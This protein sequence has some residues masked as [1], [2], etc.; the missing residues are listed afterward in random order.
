MRRASFV[1]SLLM[2]SACP[3]DPK[4]EPAPADTAPPAP[5]PHI[6]RSDKSKEDIRAFLGDQGIQVKAVAPLPP[7]TELS[8]AA[9]KRDQ[10]TLADDSKVEI[11]RFASNKAAMECQS[12]IQTKQGAAWDSVSDNYFVHGRW[13]IVT[14]TGYPAD[15]RGKLQHAFDQAL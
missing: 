3:K 15:A 13:L 7:M 12:V 9:D 2:L 10:L 14:P 1:C 8:C 11:D 4:P 6:P 5:A